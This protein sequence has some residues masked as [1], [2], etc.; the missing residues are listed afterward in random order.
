MFRIEPYKQEFASR[1]NEFVASSKNATFLFD[2]NYMD[3]HADR[4]SDISI[5]FY[6]DDNLYAL[7][8]ANQKND[9]VYSHQG[10]TYG[11]LLLNAKST[12]IDVV[13]IMESLN[14][15]YRNKGIHKVVYKS[16]PY[17]YHKI[18]AQEDLYA[19]Y[20]QKELKLIGRNISSVI[21]QN[22]KLKFSEL[23]RRCVKKA[24][25]NNLVV[26]ES[27]DYSIFWQI[28]ENNLNNKYGVLPVHTLD[29]IMLLHSRFPQNIKLYMA[30]DGECA[31]G[32]TVLY[33]SAK[34]V[35]VQYISANAVG[36]ANGALDLIFDELIND[37]Y[38][39]YEYFDFGQSTEQMGQ[40]LNESL[41]FQK[42][43]FGGRGVVYDIYE[44]S[45]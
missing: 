6:K 4:F 10:L 5:L 2:R 27:G 11:G 34:T 29:E 31:I 12:A 35:H 38:A 3:Y 43:G 22:S 24:K 17:I 21:F 9:I 25:K 39:G 33:I 23:R 20:K 42:E 16:I 13:N 28:L 26:Q 30:Y 18:P 36:K 7:F 37:I 45:L 15:Y 19:L 40:V 41:I 32:G 8:P 44:Y 14:D 1:W